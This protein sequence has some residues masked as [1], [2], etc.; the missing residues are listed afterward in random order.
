MQE[1]Y[2]DEIEKMEI[3]FKHIHGQCPYD[4]HGRI[5]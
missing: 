3:I 2:Q 4:E 5:R 1:R